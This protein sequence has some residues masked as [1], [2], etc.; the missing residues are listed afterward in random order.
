MRGTESV[1]GRVRPIDPSMTSPPPP[2]R[3]GDRRRGDRVVRGRAP[4][5]D[6]L[7]RPVLPG[8]GARPHPVTTSGRGSGS[9][10]R[11]A[12]RSQGLDDDT[13]PADGPVHRPRVG[14]DPTTHTGTLFRWT[15]RG[16][17]SSARTDRGRLKA[18]GRRQPSTIARSRRAARAR[19]PGSR[20]AHVA[21]PLV[22]ER[23]EADR[24]TSRP[25]DRRSSVVASRASFHGRRR[26][27]ANTSA[28][29]RIRSV[30]AA[31]AA[32]RIQGTDISPSPMAIAS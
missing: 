32:S 26:D 11:L 12:V 7:E 10:R 22:V 19:D 25:P 17:R 28:P 18:N 2:H 9:G 27:G 5:D 31:I 24:Q 6:D 15:G 20:L 30:R 8:P 14:Q 21:E 16:R 3:A 29:S 13:V 23:A 4:I 1:R